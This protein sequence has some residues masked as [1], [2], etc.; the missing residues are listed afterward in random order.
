MNPTIIGMI[1]FAC[2]FAG[3]LLGMWLRTVLPEH[4]VNAESRDTIKLAMGLIATMTALLL[5]L[6]TASAKNSFDTVNTAVKQTAMDLLTLDR[7]RALQSR[8]LNLAEVPFGSFGFL[9]PRHATMLV[10]L[11]ACALSVGS[12]VFLILELDGP[13]DG[14]L[15]E[16]PALALSLLLSPLLLPL[17]G[18]HVFREKDRLVRRPE[19]QHGDLVPTGTTRRAISPT[20]T[21]WRRFCGPDDSLGKGRG[22]ARVDHGRRSRAARTR[23]G[24]VHATYCRKKT[25][26][27]SVNVA[28][29]SRTAM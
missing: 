10:V 8:A 22:L 21:S 29:T 20:W 14:L 4:H 25:V 1:V 13:F 2:T 5:G 23:N 15:S 27:K 12:A 28:K 3:A 17:L 9:A 11:F 24:T 19:R 26:L 6:V 16:S 7:Q 18:H